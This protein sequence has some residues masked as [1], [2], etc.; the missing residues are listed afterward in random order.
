MIALVLAVSVAGVVTP[1]AVMAQG[2]RIE[3]AQNEKPRTLWDLLF[4]GGEEQAA[5]AQPQQ[6]AQSASPSVTVLA[7]AEPEVEKA[8]NATRLAVMG[9]SLAIDLTR[10]LERAHAEDPNI[11]VY[12]YGVSSSGFVRDDFFDWN[13]QVAELIAEDAFDIAVMIIG[14]NDRQP[15]GDAAPL[16]DE[17]REAY[18]A[19]LTRFL[20]QLRAAGKPAIWVGLPPMEAS[21][22]SAAIA[23]I[24]SLH[25]L[26]AF[27][28]GA[29]FVD[30]YERFVAEDGSYTSYGPDLSGQNVSMRKSDGIHF[31]AAGSDKLAF[32]IDQSLRRFYRGGS[33][34]IEVADVLEG[35]DAQTMMRPPFQG[36]GQIRL[37]EVAG[38]VVPLT[39]APPKAV[40]LISA[41]APRRDGVNF[42]LDELIMAPAGRADDF[43]VGVVADEE[44]AEDE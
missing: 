44:A 23:Q 19:R 36:L 2:E 10:A 12:G 43:G 28:G 42:N 17:W 25:R 3:V 8:E 11:V 35:T 15:I 1:G 18:S 34:S 31:S 4:G 38:A 24:S 5:P 33:I 30:I 13:A 29:E 22:Y 26:A 40:E 41:T 32:F 27:S 6:P 16:T 14:I 37:L 39:D 20:N 21:S 7:P 9:D